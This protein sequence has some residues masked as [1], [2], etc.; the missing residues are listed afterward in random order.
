MI[1]YL[2]NLILELKSHSYNLNESVQEMLNQ[3]IEQDVSVQQPVD[4]KGVKQLLC[5]M[6]TYKI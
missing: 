4:V 1:N 3:I 2:K 6:H 5:A